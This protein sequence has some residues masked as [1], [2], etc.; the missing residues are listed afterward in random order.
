MHQLDVPGTRE[1]RRGGETGGGNARI[2]TNMISL[3]ILFAKTVRAIGDHN[4]GQLE[5][6][7]RL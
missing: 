2:K 5:S 6:I 1:R 7:Q 3:A 4:R